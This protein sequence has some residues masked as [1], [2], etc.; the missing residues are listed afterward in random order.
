MIEV[1]LQGAFV[2]SIVGGL[3]KVLYS[4]YINCFLYF[5]SSRCVVISH[6]SDIVGDMVQTS[7]D[8]SF[9]LHNFFALM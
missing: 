1:L 3:K 8:C 6:L 9:K 2:V 7:Q 4:L 5:I